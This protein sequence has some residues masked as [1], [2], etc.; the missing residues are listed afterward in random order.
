MQGRE[1]ENL[2]PEIYESAINYLE[3]GLKLAEKLQDLAT[4]SLC[5][6]SLGIAYLVIGQHQTAIKYLEMGFRTAQV[7]GDLYTQGCNLAYLSETYYQLLN[8]EKA[9]YTGSL[10]VYL[11]EQIA[12]QEWQQPAVLLNTI[13]RQI[14][15]DS[16]QE[17]L[18]KNRAKIISVIG[19]DGYD[20]I[21]EL[22]E[23]L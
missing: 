16:F 23:G 9:V 21:P 22:L 19:V 14:G 17:L 18:G 13:I 3:R 6:S 2:E 5:F 4:Q 15:K 7:T 10:A 11:L 1:L 8:F 12:S 20:Y